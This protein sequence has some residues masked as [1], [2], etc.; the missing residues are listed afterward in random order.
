MKVVKLRQPQTRPKI[1]LRRSLIALAVSALG[2]GGLAFA[3]APNAQASWY[4]VD[5]CPPQHACLYDGST[6]SGIIGAYYY[7]GYYDL[8]NVLGF[9]TLANN[10]TG[11]AWAGVCSGYKGKGC[12]SGYRSYWNDYKRYAVVIY[13]DFTEVNSIRLTS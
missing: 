11:E 8:N 5:R 2:I 7:Y 9:K 10:Q 3:S 4:T 6:Q 12:H 13:G 1:N